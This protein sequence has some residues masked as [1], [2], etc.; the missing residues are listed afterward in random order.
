MPDEFDPNKWAVPLSPL[1]PGGE[2]LGGRG[3]HPQPPTPE[4]HPLTPVLSPREEGGFI[5]THPRYRAWLA[6]CGVTSADAALALPGEVVSGHADRH[7]VR[8]ELHGG[9]GHRVVYLKRE[10]VAGR[11]TRLRN[12]LA[13]F[14]WVSRSERE[15]MTLAKL[16]AAGLSGPQWLAYGEDAA[17]RGFLLVDELAGAFELRAFLADNQLT[18]EDRRLL[19]ERIGRTL[20]EL[21]EAGFGT[22]ELAAKHL[23]VHPG[24]LTV[25]PIDWQT[26]ATAAPTALTRWFAALHA[27]LADDLADPADRL[28]V[29]WAYRRTVRMTR[30]RGA[31]QERFGAVVRRIVELA[32]RL[33]GKS[34]V[35]T[36]RG[37]ADVNQ[38]LVWLDGEAAVAVPEVAA[39]WPTP[40]VSE[41]FYAAHGTPS[42]QR[43]TFADGRTAVLVRTAT[44]DPL[45]RLTAA[46][47]E[48]PWRSPSATAARMLFHLQRHGIPAPRL[49]AFGQRVTSLTAAES[50]LV[51]ELPPAISSLPVVFARPEM[52]PRERG[53]L[54]RG[55]GR[56]L[57][58]LHD[59]GCRPAADPGPDDPLF[60]AVGDTELSVEIGSPFAVRLAKRVSTAARRADVRSFTARLPRTDRARVLAGYEADR[61]ARK[62]LARGLRAAWA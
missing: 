56:L 21:H 5:V 9:S 47:R 52:P 29:L 42:R 61:A 35:R 4:S 15:A 57:R 28:R 20:A 2:G 26:S 43:I 59:A 36:Q 58:K 31:R 3:P 33:A 16:E 54:L 51:A 11:R 39:V 27:T 60:L 19:A 34:S 53:E 12:R 17:G 46:M 30:G 10:H 18:P 8:V 7:V 62:S 24:T 45:G 38:R 32:N 44:T 50:F 37:V 6:R 1:S 41:P 25:T 22:P 13:G 55:C 14:G 40:A 48:R 23:F 49:L